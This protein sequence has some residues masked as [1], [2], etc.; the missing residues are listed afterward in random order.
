[1]RTSICCFP[2]SDG[3]PRAASGSLARRAS[4]LVRAVPSNCRSS[5]TPPLRDEPNSPSGGD[6]RSHGRSAGGIWIGSVSARDA[7]YSTCAAYLSSTAMA[8]RNTS[9]RLHSPS[10]AV[11]KAVFPSYENADHI[12]ERGLS[13][14]EDPRNLRTSRLCRCRDRLLAS[15]HTVQGVLARA[16]LIGG[17][18]AVIEP[19]ERRERVEWRRHWTLV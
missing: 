11:E 7:E 6:S 10:R 16:A 15:Q 3:R 13:E 5:S 14:V 12:A 2:Q 18:S 19:H 4:V 8:C 1:M 9:R 17:Q